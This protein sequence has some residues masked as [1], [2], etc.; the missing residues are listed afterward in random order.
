M[1]DV[2]DQVTGFLV[3][4]HHYALQERHSLF[5]IAILGNL[6]V[7]VKRRLSYLCHHRWQS[8]APLVAQLFLAPP[9]QVFVTLIS[10]NVTRRPLVRHPSSW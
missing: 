1:L 7:A 8:P 9:V 3:W 5:L 2:S 4:L 10:A 6:K